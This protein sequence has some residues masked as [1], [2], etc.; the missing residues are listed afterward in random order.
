MSMTESNVGHLAC[1]WD[2]RPAWTPAQAAAVSDFNNRTQGLFNQ[3][4]DLALMGEYAKLQG[5]YRLSDVL[6]PR[7]EVG[8]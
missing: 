6:A 7:A 3:V 2:A 8:S 4:R 1:R 5:W